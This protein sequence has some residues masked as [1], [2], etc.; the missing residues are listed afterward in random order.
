MRGAV[1][2]LACAAGLAGCASS[3]PIE[4]PEPPAQGAVGA[5]LIAPAADTRRMDAVRHQRFIHPNLDIAAMPAYPQD[6]L[7][8]RLA[9]VLVCVDAVIDVEGLVS[10]AAP[11]ID[12]ECAPPADLDTAAFVASALDAV[13]TWTYAPALLCVAP[14]DFEGGDPCVATGV[15]ETA[16]AVRLSYAFRF[17]QSA[18]TPQVERVGAP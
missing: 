3:P 7:P 16:T 12:G 10:A 2:L 11:R 6:L 9:P 14:E 1:T 17:S 4:A 13:R 15:V 18:G 5:S 8:L